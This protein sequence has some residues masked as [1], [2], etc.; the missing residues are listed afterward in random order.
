MFG[1]GQSLIISHFCSQAWAIFKNKYKPGEP[2]DPATWKTRMR[3]ALTKSPEFEEVPKLSRLDGTEPYKVY[4][5]VPGEE[6]HV[7][8]EPILQIA[9]NLSAFLRN[10]RLIRIWFPEGNP[11]PCPPPLLSAYW[12]LNEDHACLIDPL[13]PFVVFLGKSPTAPK[14]KKWEP[15]TGSLGKESGSLPVS[16]SRMLGNL[17]RSSPAKS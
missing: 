8:E 10:P 4:R 14:S 3:C 7:G 16:V 17:C 13:S 15:T 11:P 9:W 5:L 12:V 1:P 6:Q 2:L